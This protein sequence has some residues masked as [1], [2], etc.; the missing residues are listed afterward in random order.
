MK[1]SRI[2]LF[3]LI[4]GLAVLFGAVPA[5]AAVGRAVVLS[6]TE[7]TMYV[8]QTETLTMYVG[9]G[10]MA[11]DKW[12]STRKS[13]AT[14]SSK[15]VVKA[16]KAGKTTILCT[17]GFGYDLECTVTVKKRLEVSGYLNKNYL[18]LARKVPAAEKNTYNDPAGIGNLYTFSDYSGT[19]P[20]FRYDLK[21]KKISMLQIAD[22]VN[23]QEQAR[24][25]LY[26]VSLDMTAKQAK[27]A[28]KAN[29]CKYR[30]IS[31]YAAGYDLIY[32][33]SGHQITLKFTDGKVSAIQWNR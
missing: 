27:K 6:D 29:K 8:G 7:L 17:T 3:A 20:F 4:M 32:K 5:K 10:E 22:A 13:V 15:G 28:M 31:K 25:T 18:K 24:L 33:R 2:M 11:P 19:A 23:K 30:K 1:R 9:N 21:T 12:A 26:G 16:R 14:V